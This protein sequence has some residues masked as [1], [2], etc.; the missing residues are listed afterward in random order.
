VLSGPSALLQFK[1]WFPFMTAASSVLAALFPLTC[2]I[3]GTHNG[4]YWEFVPPKRRCTCTKLYALTSEETIFYSQQLTETNIFLKNGLHHSRIT[5]SF[6]YEM[7]DEKA[8]SI[9]HNNNCIMRIGMWYHV[10][11]CFH[12]FEQSW[13]KCCAD[14]ALS[15]ALWS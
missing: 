3:R 5:I 13:Y 15:S 9:S 10:H 4:D 7:Q 11:V 14:S 6:I 2:R 12:Y 1:V 8:A